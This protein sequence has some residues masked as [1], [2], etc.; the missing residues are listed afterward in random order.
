MDGEPAMFA[1]APIYNGPVRAGTLVYQIPFTLIN[2][3]MTSGAEKGKGEETYL[4]GPDKRMRSDSL[5]SP[6][7]HSVKASLS[8]TVAQNGVD[9]EAVRKALAGESGTALIRDYRGE[10]VLSSYAPLN[11]GGL[12]WSIV[13]E[14]D[15]AKA[16]ALS[17]HLRNMAWIIGGVAGFI[18]ALCALWIAASLSKP[19][20]QITD[21]A[22]AV[23]S[24]QLNVKAHVTSKDELRILADAF[25]GM[26]RKLK[27]SLAE[28]EQKAA[29][30]QKAK[31]FWKIQSERMW[32]LWNRWVR[33][34]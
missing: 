25:N 3:I 7:T 1:G 4:V 22:Q 15:E 9:T 29:E 11:I 34:I 8:G 30:E 33:G 10:K 26:V 20:R 24:G 19:V 13:A 32:V 18:V 21:T 28:V 31:A 23:R 17:R 5:L 14:M 27:D 6:K 12:K 2:S 16:F